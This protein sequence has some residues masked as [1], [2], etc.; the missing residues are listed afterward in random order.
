MKQYLII[1]LVMISVAVLYA[2][3]RVIRDFSVHTDDG[4][5]ILD[6]TSGVEAG[7]QS[8][9]VQRSFDG[10][11]FNAISHMDPSG[12]DHDYRYI[13]NDLFKGN[14][15]SYYYRISGV[16]SDNKRYY[17]ETRKITVSSSGINRTWGSIKAMFR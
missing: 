4:R 6:W 17:S 12:D 15:S 1:F 11:Q 14:I 7:L 10:S 8:Y 2:G 13:D 16:L 5:A 3:G 9:E